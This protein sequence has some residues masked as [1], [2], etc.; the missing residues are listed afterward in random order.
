MSGWTSGRPENAADRGSE[1]LK[2]VVK[3]M[4]QYRRRHAGFTLVELLVVLA[5]IGTLIGLFLPAV[6]KVRYAAAQVKCANNIKQIGLALHNYHDTLGSFPPAQVT[7][8]Y[9]E[10]YW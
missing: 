2:E 4:N 10:Y 9:P 5:I 6:Q 1:C 3:P 8:L 7:R